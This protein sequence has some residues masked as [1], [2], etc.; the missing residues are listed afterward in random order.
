MNGRAGYHSPLRRAQAAATRER[1]LAAC[2]SLMEAGADLTYSAIARTAG[3]QE[4]T[5]YRHFPAKADLEAGLDAEL[6]AAIELRRR[7][8]SNFLGWKCELDPAGHRCNLSLTRTLEIVDLIKSLC[9]RASSDQQAVK[10]LDYIAA[11]SRCKSASGPPG[12]NRR[13]AAS[14]GKI[15]RR[16]SS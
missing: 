5:V 8:L 4:R 6:P 12:K 14:P 16:F 2:A 15:G 9:D 10:F 1:I 13:P 7:A 11:D 3:V